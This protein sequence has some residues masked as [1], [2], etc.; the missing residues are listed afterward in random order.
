MTHT[1]TSLYKQKT[2]YNAQLLIYVWPIFASQT[3]HVYQSSEVSQT[4]DS[5]KDVIRLEGCAV[6]WI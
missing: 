4:S 5:Q 3:C 6:T 1:I 2:V